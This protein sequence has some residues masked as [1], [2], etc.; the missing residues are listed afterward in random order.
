ME[1]YHSV[2]DQH[3]HISEIVYALEKSNSEDLEAVTEIL[4]K[5]T[6]LPSEKIKPGLHSF[7]ES[8][9]ELRELPFYE[10]ATPEEWSQAFM[11]WVESHRSLNLPQLSDAAISRESLYGERG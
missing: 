10:Q 1:E 3:Q 7:V 11:Q 8:L 6:N 9:I 4:S 5:I 2:I